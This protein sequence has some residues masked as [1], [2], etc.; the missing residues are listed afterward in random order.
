MYP[1]TIKRKTYCYETL[2]INR[3][4]TTRSYGRCEP[5][6]KKACK[7][8]NYNQYLE[9]KGNNPDFKLKNILKHIKYSKINSQ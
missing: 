9:N 4:I 5:N 7:T 3:K 6:T 8:C 2:R 1:K